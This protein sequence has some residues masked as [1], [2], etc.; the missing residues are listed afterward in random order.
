[1]SEFEIRIKTG[2]IVQDG[3]TEGHGTIDGFKMPA[4]NFVIKNERTLTVDQWLK[5]PKAKE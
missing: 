2:N 5:Q 3:W 1:M 4:P